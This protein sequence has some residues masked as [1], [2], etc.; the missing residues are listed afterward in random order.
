MSG[1]ICV[2][3]ICTYYGIKLTACAPACA[4]RIDGRAFVCSKSVVHT[5]TEAM[6]R[7]P[8]SPH[9]YVQSYRIYD[10]EIDC[11]RDDKIKKN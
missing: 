4:I 7:F 2:A 5:E 9:E 3:Y 10:T 8:A 11:F 1:I 6:I